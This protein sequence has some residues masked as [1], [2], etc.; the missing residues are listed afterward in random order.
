MY[1]SVF[2][3]VIIPFAGIVLPVVMW[4]TNKDQSS[5]IDKHGKNILNF[6][7]SWEYRQNKQCFSPTAMPTNNVNIT[8]NQ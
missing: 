7:I 3:N 8:A 2:A 1:L 5:L 4:A 6:I